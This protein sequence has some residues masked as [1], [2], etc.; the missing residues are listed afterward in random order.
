MLCSPLSLEPLL[1]FY[2]IINI[3]QLQQEIMSESSKF[4]YGMVKEK[5]VDGFIN[6]ILED[7]IDFDY[8]TSYQ[9][10]NN[11]VYSFINELHIKIIRYLQEDKT[12]ENNAY[13]EIQDQIFSDYL[14]LKVY[15]IIYRKHAVSD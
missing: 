13:Y 11:D 9:S 1:T 3:V 5:T 14:K 15:G 2:K 4:K 7:N 12:P 10:D 6:D 8:S